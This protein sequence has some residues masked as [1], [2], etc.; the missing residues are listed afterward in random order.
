[1]TTPEQ[2]KAQDA[3]TAK[4][5]ARRRFTRAG[6]GAS[7]VLLTLASQPGMAQT[8]CT[9]PSGSLSGGLH[10]RLPPNNIC[11]GVSPGYWKTHTSWPAP[12]TRDTCNS[13]GLITA[14]GTL[15]SNS[16][17][18]FPM[19]AMKRTYAKPPA[20]TNPVPT[21]YGSRYCTFDRILEHQSFDDQ[22]FGMHLAATML[23]IKSGRISFLT[24]ERLMSMWTE[25]RAHGYFEPTAGVK[26]YPYDI[27]NYLKGTMS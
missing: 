19:P 14:Y 16:T 6:L 3:L 4:G 7:G 26:W 8:I 12:Y 15:F 1:V 11:Q 20:G 17:L 5:A 10:S 25:V 18:G 2:Q 13:S 9:T 21:D 23:N 27:V 22:N 24:V